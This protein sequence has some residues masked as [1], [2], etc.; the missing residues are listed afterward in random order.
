MQVRLSQVPEILMA[1]WEMGEIPYLEGPPGIGKSDAVKQFLEALKVKLGNPP[2]FFYHEFRGSTAEPTDLSGL[3]FPINNRTTYLKPTWWPEAGPGVFFLDEFPQATQEMMNAF[4]QVFDRV[5]IGADFP[6]DVMIVLAGNRM[7]DGAAVNRIPSH[8]RNRV[9]HFEVAFAVDDWTAYNLAIGTRPEIVAFGRFKPEMFC[10]CPP[11]DGKPFLSGRSLTK[12]SKIL[13]QGIAKPL[14]L[15]FYSSLVGEEAAVALTGFLRIA[16][17]VVSPDAVL[18]DP[19]NAPIPK[20]KSAIM[21]VC[22]ALTHRC[23]VSNFDRICQ[24]ALRLAP[25]DSILLVVGC[26]QKDNAYRKNNPHVKAV[27]IDTL[28]GKSF[29]EWTVKYQDVLK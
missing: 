24:Y 17:G 10:E 14:D 16:G 11:K 25:E 18:L 27:P 19:G 1:C 15:A 23:S 2:A 22:T 26:I 6:K 28:G 13:E 3:P 8:I 7:A 20:E 4:S 9:A 21:A 12:C 5:A 29:T